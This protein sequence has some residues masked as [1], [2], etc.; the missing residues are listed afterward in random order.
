M[1]EFNENYMKEMMFP[2]SNLSDRLLALANELGFS[3]SGLFPTT[4]LSFRQ[5]VRDMC[6]SGRCGSYG[7]RW[8][9]PPYCGTLEESIAKAKQF[10]TGIL[11]QMTGNME[12]DFDV[13]CMQE[14]EQAVKDKLALFVKELHMQNIACLPMTA[15]TCTKCKKCTCPD[16]PCRFPKEAFTSME[17]YGLIVSDVCTSAGVKYNYGTKTITFTTC[18]LFN[19]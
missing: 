17:A 16:E 7:T 19:E 13:E 2:E 11:L 4:A 1:P 18:V 3:H 5:E 12:D 6:S 15:G 10:N 8:T 14:T 9:C